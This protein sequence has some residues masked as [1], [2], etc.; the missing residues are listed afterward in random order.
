MSDK[1]VVEQTSVT[2]AQMSEFWRQVAAGDLSG[3]Q[4]QDL[5]EHR[6]PFGIAD[7]D[8]AKTYGE[9]GMQAEFA[10]FVG[11]GVFDMPPHHVVNPLLWTMPMIKGITC[12]RVVAGYRAKKV[13]V[14]TYVPD[15]DGNVTVND[16]DPNRG[17]YTVGFRR[18]IEADEENAG[19]SANVLATAGHKGI[20]LCERLVLGFGY[21]VTT[22]QHL[23]VKTWTMCAGSRYSF[24]YVPR[25]CFGPGGRLVCVYWCSLG[26]ADGSLRPRSAVSPV[27]L[28]AQAA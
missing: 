24:G 17:S 18:T 9:L 14:Y 19:K 25:V 16:R 2:A 4:V 7:I 23:D 3:K 1:V 28:P 12:N 11:K 5:L 21:Y 6:N 8:W 13:D 22:G 27:I 20:V 10:A 26:D 15:L